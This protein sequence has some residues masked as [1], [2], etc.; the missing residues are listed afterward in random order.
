[1][2]EIWA[3][4]RDPRTSARDLASL[5]N[6]CPPEREKLVSARRSTIFGAALILEPGPAGPDRRYRL[7][8]RVRGSVTHFSGNDYDLTAAGALLPAYLRSGLR[9][10]SRRKTSSA[11]H[12][13]LGSN[14]LRHAR[15]QPESPDGSVPLP[16]P[17]LCRRLLHPTA[18]SR[19]A[20][21]ESYQGPPLRRAVRARTRQERGAGVPA[22]GG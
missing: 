3:R 5:T 14:P 22:R 20:A 11:R 17:S 7:M 2:R 8:M 12:Q 9:S 13:H 15:D 18:C 16:L 1:M 4:I 10:A 21:I 19:G 6:A